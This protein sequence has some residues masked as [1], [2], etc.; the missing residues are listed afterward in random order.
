MSIKTINEKNE[1]NKLL[2]REIHHRV[3]NNLQIISSLLGAQ[4]TKHV[5]N[6]TITTILQ[7]S[8]NKI[9]SIAIIHQNLYKGNQFAKVAVSSYIKELI[10]NIE[11]SFEK[12]NANVKIN[13]D[14]DTQEIQMRLAVPLGLI[15]NELITNAYKYA[16]INNTEKENIISLRF[17]ELEHTDAYRLIVKDNGKGLPDDFD[18][19]RL[20]SFGLKLVLGLTEQLKGKLK[21]TQDKGTTF[22][23]V[24][25]NTSDT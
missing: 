11:K 18:T 3:K 25:E 9:R 23:I 19:D 13:L 24:I 22:T 15:I 6:N 12:D 17:H 4:V 20:S 2:M 5:D 21:I 1:E 8:Q 7:E 14:I 16:F 10:K